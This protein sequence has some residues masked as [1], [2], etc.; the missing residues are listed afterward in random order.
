MG[1]QTSRPSKR[2]RTSPNHVPAETSDLAHSSIPPPATGAHRLCLNI[3]GTRMQATRHTLCALGPSYFTS[4]LTTKIPTTD[5]LFI[6]TSPAAF[7][8][9]FGALL[10]AQAS[11]TKAVNVVHDGLDKFGFVLHQLLDFLMLS[12]TVGRPFHLPQLASVAACDSAAFFKAGDFLDQEFISLELGLRSHGLQGG[13]FEYLRGK[14]QNP[15]AYRLSADGKV[16]TRGTVHVSAECNCRD[17]DSFLEANAAN[18][19]TTDLGELLD[20]T[21]SA[22]H[23]ERRLAILS[24]FYNDGDQCGEGLNLYLEEAGFEDGAEVDAYE[25][26]VASRLVFDLGPKFML[27]LQGALIGLTSNTR[28]PCKCCVRLD[29]ADSHAEL[30]EG[31]P[32][33]LAGDLHAH[34]ELLPNYGLDEE[35]NFHFRHSL[36]KLQAVRPLPIGRL[37]SV[38]VWSCASNLDTGGDAVTSGTQTARKWRLSAF[39]V[40]GDLIELPEELSSRDSRCPFQF[41]ERS[42]TCCQYQLNTRN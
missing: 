1:V 8:V 15:C 28:V 23:T 14:R 41:D 18:A 38:E 5:E 29:V 7:E 6:E 12:W 35:G 40:F 20:S 31:L 37:L 3:A 24:E 9:V 32:G 33:G 34:V 39:E 30:K 26:T 4:Y 19:A 21:R 11:L 42:T 2:P 36:V 27:R 13:V 10:V 16:S 22:E 25:N 17:T